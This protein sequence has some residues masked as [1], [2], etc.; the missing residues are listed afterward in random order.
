[1]QRKTLRPNTNI[2]NKFFVVISSLF[3]SINVMALEIDPVFEKAMCDQ[4]IDVIPKQKGFSYWRDT[5]VLDWK[6]ETIWTEFT[7]TCTIDPASYEFDTVTINLFADKNY[8]P[9][10][11]IWTTPYHSRVDAQIKCLFTSNYEWECLYQNAAY[12]DAQFLRIVVTQQHMGFTD[13]TWFKENAAA[14]FLNRAKTTIEEL[15]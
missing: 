10:G 14:V 9:T 5:E 3:I 2:M 11:S 4:M 13:S 6:D 7:E 1:M 12:F 15:L 8:V